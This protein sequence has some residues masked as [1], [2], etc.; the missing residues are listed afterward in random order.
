MIKLLYEPKRAVKRQ[1][2]GVEK[3]GKHLGLFVT[4]WHEDNSPCILKIERIKEVKSHTSSLSKIIYGEDKREVIVKGDKK[5][6]KLA[7]KE[8]KEKK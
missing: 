3:G 5:S 4:L 6:V 1:I 8:A 2:E 7:I